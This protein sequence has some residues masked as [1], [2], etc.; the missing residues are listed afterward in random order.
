MN[1]LQIARSTLRQF[2]ADEEGATAVEYGLIVALIA[3]VIAA[4]VGDIGQQLLG[5]FGSVKAALP[6][7]AGGG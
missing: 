7:A 3:V 4:T 1:I 5:V 2:V 6:A